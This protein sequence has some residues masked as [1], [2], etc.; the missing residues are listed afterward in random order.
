MDVGSGPADDRT[1]YDE[2]AETK[3][4]HYACPHCREEGEYPV[5]WLRR[6][7][8]KQPPP[9]LDVEGRQRFDKARSYL[10]RVDDLLA[11]RNQRCRRR[12]DIPSQQ[13]VILL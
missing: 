9:G 8:K 4:L 13:T 1:F 3:T 6:E 5:R 10:T 7:K 2:I 12:F 11:C